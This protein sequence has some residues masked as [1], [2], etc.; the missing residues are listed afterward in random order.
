MHV[1]ISLLAMMLLLLIHGNSD[2]AQS[3]SP[4]SSPTML[5]RPT[6]TFH[7]TPSYS[8][9]IAT[10]VAD[11]ECFQSFETYAYRGPQDRSFGMQDLLPAWEIEATAIE[12]QPFSFGQV[13]LARW[14]DGHSEIWLGM[15]DSVNGFHRDPLLGI[16]QPDIQAWELVSKKINDSDMEVGRLFVTSDGTV[17]G[18][19][20]WDSLEY[21][22]LESIPVL[23]RFNENSRRFEFADG[24]L[25]LGREFFDRFDTAVIVLDA[26]D[27]FWI[28]VS[29][30]GVYRYDPVTQITEK[31]V[32]LPEYEVLGAV[33]APD[34][35]IYFQ[36]YSNRMYSGDTFLRVVEGTLFQFIPET[37]EILSVDTPKNLPFYS[38]LLVDR[39]GRLWL[40]SI[41]YREP[42]GVWY[43]MHPD[44][45]WFLNRVDE[46]SYSY[47]L[48][49]P[50]LILESSNGILW[51]T[52][53][54]DTSG[55]V[56]GTAWYD[57][58]TREGCM[59]TNRYANIVEDAESQL[60]LVVDDVLYKHPMD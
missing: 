17:W 48:A 51:Y 43:V 8:P 24:V 22:S 2:L 29:Y 28:F 55:L 59:F 19:S 53:Y 34:G 57:P 23:S 42:D 41:A 27:I 6:P 60:W 36:T 10:A 46:G 3:T 31:R 45:E 4:T 11:R 32:D 47:V 33:L 12:V 16:F 1:F 30:D 40:G 39:S 58:S 52:R 7:P 49:P 15:L 26:A 44:P 50:T 25:T 56:D 21:P 35:S 14:I 38:G 20:L 9:D 37:N 18:S 5:L 13:R 54:L